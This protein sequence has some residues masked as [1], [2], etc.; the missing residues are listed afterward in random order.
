MA[1]IEQ[2]FIPFEEQL[3][4]EEAISNA[5]RNTSGEIRLHIEHKLINYDNPLDRAAE[6]FFQIGM[7]KTEARNGVLI[8]LASEDKKFCIIGD[9]GI[10]SVV[11]LHYWDD[12]IQLMKNYFVQNKFSEG[13]IKAIDL[14]GTKLKDKFPFEA[15]DKNELKNEISFGD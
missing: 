7:D 14:I 4:I 6:L 1:K 3:L 2:T 8:Y 5:E 10:N 12:V 15:D 11:P 13:I 9:S